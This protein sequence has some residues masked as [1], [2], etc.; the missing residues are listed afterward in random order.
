MCPVIFNPSGALDVATDPSDLPEQVDGKTA[1]SGAMLRC[2]NLSLD[3]MGIA[4]TRKGTSKLNA[5]AISAPNHIVEQ[6]M[7]STYRSTCQKNSYSNSTLRF[8][9]DY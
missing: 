5:T 8:L 7:E 1:M 9:W 2:T 3:R 4:S 6:G